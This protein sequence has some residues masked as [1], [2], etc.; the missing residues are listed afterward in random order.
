MSPRRPGR[1]LALGPL[2]ALLFLFGRPAF[3]RTDTV[4]WMVHESPLIVQGTVLSGRTLPGATIA[5]DIITVKVSKTIKGTPAETI[6]FLAEV[7]HGQPWDDGEYLFFLTPTRQYTTGPV[8]AAPG[9][10]SDKFPWVCE[11]R[12]ALDE[13]TIDPQYDGA[14]HRL[15]TADAMLSA[16]R[17]E[18]ANPPAKPSGFIDAPITPRT[19]LPPDAASEVRGRV[20]RLLV[21]ERLEAPVRAWIDS[22]EPRDRVNGVEV[23]GQ[24]KSDENV[25]RLTRLL[26]DAYSWPEMTIVGSDYIIDNGQ[27]KWAGALYPVRNAAYN[28][29]VRWHAAVP[30]HVV[31]NRPK[32]PVTFLPRRGIFALAGVLIV[33]LLLGAS[34]VL[35]GR[36]RGAHIVAWS[37]GLLLAAGALWV[38]GAWR[39]DELAFTAGGN[40][41]E[42]ATWGGAV[43]LLRLKD[44]TDPAPAAITRAVRSPVVDADWELE[45]AGQVRTRVGHVG[46]TWAR[47]FV[48][49]AGTGQLE[50]VSLSLPWWMPCAVLSLPTLLVGVARLRG[51]RRRAQGLCPRCGYDLRASPAGCPECGWGRYVG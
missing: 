51:R 1:N 50:F 34:G 36:R 12:I 13:P 43:R 15:E 10:T 29:L 37:V 11:W 16:V 26:D 27:G 44:F 30:A 28:V 7:V 35:F 21:D 41:Y 3:A 20:L 47:G 17:H 39:I 49:C 8:F 46:V 32:Y 33:L 19:P 14:F 38:R 42:L 6:T 40:R 22:P 45:N 48:L 5:N 9:A 25:A 2:L 31:V 24:F 23:L 4:E 18:V